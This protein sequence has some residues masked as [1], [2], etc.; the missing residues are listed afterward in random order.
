VVKAMQNYSDHYVFC[1]ADLKNKLLH[2]LWT[3][4]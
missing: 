2:L 4:F 1:R 3:A